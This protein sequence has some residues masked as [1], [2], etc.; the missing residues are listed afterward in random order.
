MRL[1]RRKHFVTNIYTSGEID[2]VAVADMIK[3]ELGTI[4]TVATGEVIK[5][6]TY[7]VGETPTPLAAPPANDFITEEEVNE[8]VTYVGE[9]RSRTDNLKDLVYELHADVLTLRA[10]VIDLNTRVMQLEGDE[11][12]DNDDE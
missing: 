8:L 7:V 4:E 1:R 12:E 9:A 10:T 2:P 11:Y 6:Q 3:T 5:D